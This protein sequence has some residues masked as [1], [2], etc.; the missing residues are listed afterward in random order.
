MRV[1]LVSPYSLTMPGGVQGQVL[2]LARVLRHLGHETRVLAP[3]DGPPPEPGVT[4]LGR[5]IPAVANGSVA[6]IAPDPACLLRT[7]RAL[8]DESFDVV[9]LHEPLVPGP[10]LTT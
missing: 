4:P 10:C 2:A 5:S 6:P 7:L 3:C 8:R 9:H 1:G